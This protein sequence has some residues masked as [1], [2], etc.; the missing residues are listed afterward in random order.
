MKQKKEYAQVLYLKTNH[1]QK[2]IAVRVG[3]TEKTLGKWIREGDWEMLKSSLIITKEQ[4]LRRMYQQLNELNNNIAG[5]K[6][7]ERYATSK[8]ADIIS[9]LSAAIKNL[10]RDTSIA[11]VIDVFIDFSNWLKEADFEQAQVFINLQ[12]DFVKHKLKTR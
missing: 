1:T 5:R 10:E 11:D 9:K 3:V 8:E 4:E 6:E 12:D 2:D 7:G